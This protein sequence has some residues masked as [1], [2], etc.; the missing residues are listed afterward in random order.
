M[1]PNYEILKRKHM[2]KP[3]F[4]IVCNYSYS[5]EIAMYDYTRKQKKEQ[6]HEIGQWIIKYKN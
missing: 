2:T 6:D 1:E 5:N 4:L 3:F